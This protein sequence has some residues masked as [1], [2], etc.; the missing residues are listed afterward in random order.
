MTTSFHIG[1]LAKLAQN[2]LNK[3]QTG[4]EFMLLD[5]YRQTKE[6]YER[7][8]EDPV[9]RQVAFVVERMAEKAKAGAIISQSQL[10]KIH[11][12]FVRLSEN[13]KFKTVLGHLLLDNSNT[14]S[15]NNDFVRTN[16]VD[17]VGEGIKI[18]DLVDK[19]LVNNFDIMLSGNGTTKDYDQKT[20]DKGAEYVKIELASLGFSS[21]SEE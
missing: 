9:I 7:F 20:A 3:Q 5:V 17:A 18:E 14:A 1:D 11:N 6:A 16:R 13:S 4:Q 10:S 15:N 2:L 21:R 19:T 8:P 12:E